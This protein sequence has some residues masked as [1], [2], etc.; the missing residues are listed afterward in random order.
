MRY[1]PELTN[2]IL[3]WLG[4]IAAVQGLTEKAKLLWKNADVRLR[5]ILNYLASIIISILLCA[6]FLY[7]NDS[8]SFKALFLY[9]IPIWL[10]ASGV[11]DA[12]HASKSQ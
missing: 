12:F 9:A 2:L 1:S 11:Y 6:V 4:G 10:A 3:T 8:F 7:L 5:K